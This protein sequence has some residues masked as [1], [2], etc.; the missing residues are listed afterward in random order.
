MRPVRARCD[1]SATRCAKSELSVARCGATRVPPL[2]RVARAQRQVVL[3]H[4]DRHPL[5]LV[6]LVRTLNPFH[7]FLPG[8]IVG[9]AI[10][11]VSRLGA[12]VVIVDSEVVGRNIEEGS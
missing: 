6:C 12:S 1:R 3:V 2:P 11:F 4:L 5:T 10:R 9:I 8:G 7:D